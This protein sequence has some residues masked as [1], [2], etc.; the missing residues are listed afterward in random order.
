[1]GLQ[2]CV[3]HKSGVK[4]KAMFNISIH[5]GTCVEARF[6]H[7]ASVV[8]ILPIGASESVTRVRSRVPQDPLRRARRRALSVILLVWPDEITLG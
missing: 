6:D 4:E 1:M 3:L 7:Y 2:S 5:A 8:A